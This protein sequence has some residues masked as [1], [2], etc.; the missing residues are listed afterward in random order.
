M[1]LLNEAAPAVARCLVCM[2]L[3]LASLLLFEHA[4][5]ACQKCSPAA[6][7]AGGGEG[8]Y[9]ADPAK[10]SLLSMGHACGAACPRQQRCIHQAAVH[11]LH[12]TYAATLEESNSPQDA[13]WTVKQ[14]WLRLHSP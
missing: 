4:A 3:L 11:A 2:L 10:T 14:R 6:A 7:P 5:Q 8:S 13:P 1:Q 9:T 12:V